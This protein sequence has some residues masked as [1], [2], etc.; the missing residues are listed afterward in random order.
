M[1]MLH[2]TIASF[3]LE[4]FS[5]LLA[6][7]K[8]TAPLGNP[9]YKNGRQPLE[10]RRY[11]PVEGQ[12]KLKLSP[13]WQQGTRGGKHHPSG[14]E[15]H[16]QSSLQMRSQPWPTPWPTPGGTLSWGPSSA[17]PGLP[18]HRNC[19]II[20]RRCVILSHY[21]CSSSS[22]SNRKLIQGCWQRSKNFPIIGSGGN[23][24]QGD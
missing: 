17:V 8:Q 20:N 12:Q 22:W 5:C 6:V 19:A 24:G 23:S 3:S 15:H 21:V 1:I 9:S 7:R 2:K 13:L 18:T 16:P 4:S 14:E 10:T 11:P